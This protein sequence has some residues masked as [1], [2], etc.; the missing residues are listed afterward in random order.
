MT[1]EADRPTR[2]AAPWPLTV[3]MDWCGEHVP[4]KA[5]DDAPP[6]E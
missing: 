6:E 3:A 2:A 1:D 5:D 4:R